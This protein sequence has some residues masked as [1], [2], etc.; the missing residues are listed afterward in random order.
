M[1]LKPK[2]ASLPRWATKAGR[3][4]KLAQRRR[5]QHGRR[6]HLEPPYTDPQLPWR[7]SREGNQPDDPYRPLHPHSFGPSIT[8]T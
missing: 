5:S 7:G 6:R 3:P 1:A 2:I 4:A 8:M